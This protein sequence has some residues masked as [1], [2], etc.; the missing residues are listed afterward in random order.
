MRRHSITQRG[1]HRGANVWN[2]FFEI[3]NQPLDTR[4]FEIW[5]RPTQV[6]GNDWKLGFGGELSNLLGAAVSQRTNDGVTP[7]VRTQDGRHRFQC[8]NVKKIQQKGRDDVISVMTKRDLR[9]AF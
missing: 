8:A 5:L 2:L 6:A 7:I 4:A 9:T 3:R 1:Q